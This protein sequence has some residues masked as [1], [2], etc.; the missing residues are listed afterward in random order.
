MIWHLYFYTK[1]TWHILCSEIC[2]SCLLALKKSICSS[3]H[4]LSISISSQAYMLICSASASASASASV[5]LL[6]CFKK[7]SL[8]R[9]PSR[10]LSGALCTISIQC[11]SS[12][13]DLPST[14]VQR[15][16]SFHVSTCISN[17]LSM[18]MK[19]VNVSSCLKTPQALT[20]FPVGRF[21]NMKYWY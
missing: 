18:F 1:C 12:T 16:S 7:C 15:R 14:H 5:H 6:I 17:V 9:F 13:Y 10:D 4:L 3:S 20:I 19:Q 21:Y 8:N 11:N 2:I